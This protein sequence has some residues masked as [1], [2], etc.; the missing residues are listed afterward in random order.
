MMFTN[1][2]K[3]LLVRPKMALASL[4]S[5]R[6]YQDS[7]GFISCPTSKDNLSKE[8]RL[9]RQVFG[10]NKLGS[11]CAYHYGIPEFSNVGDGFLYDTLEKLFDVSI[12]S[13]S[14]WVRRSLLKGEILGLEVSEINS[15]ADVLVLGGHG[16]FMVDSNKNNNSGWQFNISL[17]NLKRLSAPLVVFGVGYNRFYDQPDFIPVFSEHLQ[18]TLEKSIFFGIRNHG[19]INK[20]KEYLPSALHERIRFQPCPTT[21]LLSFF[22]ALADIMQPKQYNKI[23][24]CLAFDRLSHRLGP[25][26]NLVLKQIA[27]SLKLIESE[28]YSVEILD[29]AIPNRQSPYY[30]LF[31]DL[32][33]QIR[34]LSNT[35]PCLL[36]RAYSGYSS[37]IGMR[38][39]SLMI[40][41]GLGI[42]VCSINTQ[43]KQKWFMESA[44]LNDWMIDIDNLAGASNLVDKILG[45]YDNY[46]SNVEFVMKKQHEFH[47]L[48]LCNMGLIKS[49]LPKA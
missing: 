15:K 43:D 24:V 42:P 10:L 33:F 18:L 45:I 5:L 2:V 9:Q 30:R 14:R 39:H 8:K 41:F 11:I 26:P 3:N 48:T 29:H 40:P 7:L 31:S 32:G 49:H 13:R 16:L 1:A 34:N 28:G 22:P 46:D 36:C 4:A 47:A 44:G 27:D 20:L 19:S 12:Q 6:P 35:P 25:N 38:G 37:I 17:D 23:G 21:M